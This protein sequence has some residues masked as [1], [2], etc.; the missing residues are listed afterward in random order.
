MAT[1]ITSL[2][3]AAY[4]RLASAKRHPKEC[5]SHAVHRAEWPTTGT[6]WS[7]LF[8]ALEELPPTEPEVLKELESTQERDLPPIDKWH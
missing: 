6:R 4:S 7:D 3:L 2:D 1:K 8:A 5:F